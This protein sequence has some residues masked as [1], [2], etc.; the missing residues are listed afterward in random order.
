M[1]PWTV[2]V[3]LTGNMVSM[4]GGVA[5]S[6]EKPEEVEI[7]R[8]TELGLKE[9]H[10]RVGDGAGGWKWQ[11]GEFRFL[12]TSGYQLMPF[13]LAQ[14]DNGEV[15]L[16]GALTQNGQNEKPAVAFS[17]DRGATWSDWLLIPEAEGRPMGLAYL[18]QGNLTWQ[19]WPTRYYSSDYG[20]TWP[21]RIPVPPAVEGGTWGVEGNPLVEQEESGD[22][23][24]AETGYSGIEGWPASPTIDYIRWSRD[25]GRTWTPAINPPEWLWED[26]YEGRTYSRGVSEG[27]LVRADNGWLVAA[28]RTDMPA[29]WIPSSNDNYEGAGVSLSQDNGQ[30]WS[31]LQMLHRGG[32]MHM[33]FV[34]QENG[35]L[36]MIYVMRQDIA[37]EGVHYAS[38]RRGCGALVSQDQGQTWDL[39]REYRLHEFDYATGLEGPHE[40]ISALA[41]GHTCST[42]LD[43]GRILTAYGHYISNGIALIR[44]SP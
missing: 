3:A 21:T 43:D 19:S 24:L 17:S 37:P 8:G 2:Q 13:G 40:G 34:K 32:R 14:M 31:P 35:D 18:G 22:V 42:R 11:K 15:I 30:T 25:G 39:S 9:H 29:R 33:H 16:L 23:V 6:S 10:L 41:C 27:S 36:V 28:L 1:I 44:W 7:A 20:R 38:Y 12:H 4:L 26:T 5:V